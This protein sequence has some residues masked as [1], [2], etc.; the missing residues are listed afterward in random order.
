M[1]KEGGHKNE[2]PGSIFPDSIIR[3]E[4]KTD[5]Y[6]N[7]TCV[8]IKIKMEK[9]SETRKYVNQLVYLYENNT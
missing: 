2:Q 9:K 6:L 8:F 4:Y 3:S 5:V 7:V 1:R